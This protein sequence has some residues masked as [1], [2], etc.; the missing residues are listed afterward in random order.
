MDTIKRLINI[1]IPITTCTLRCNYCYITHH[2]LFGGA[3]PNFKYSP[4]EVRRALSKERLGGTC[5]I[6]FCAGGE[7]L[8]P[9]NIVS[10]FKALLDEGHYLFIVTNGTVTKRFDEIAA[11]PPEL[12][13]RTFF[14]FSY[15]YREF[16]E[17]G[18]LDKFFS[19]VNKI[20]SAGASFTLELTPSDEDIPF[21]DEIKETAIKNVGA[22][23]HVTV[24]RNEKVVGELPILTNMSKSDYEKTWSVFNSSFFDYKMSIFGKKR[25][26]FCYAGAWSVY[27]NFVTGD[28]TQCYCS[29]YQQN[30]FENIE[31]PI[32][33]MP[34]GNNCTMQHCY[35]GHSMIVLGTIPEL[36]APTLAEIRNRVCSDGSEWLYPEMKSF[37]GT[38]LYETNQEYSDF[39]KFKVNLEMK[40]R[41]RIR[42]L[43][44]FAG[45]IKRKLIK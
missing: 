37:M 21:I 7:T 32:R 20:H 15:H 8:L 18:L 1:H 24:A 5:L 12:L 35:N 11:L 38:R 13:K 27:L 33:F 39:Q 25:K 4:D 29:H 28:M 22:V 43:R 10:Y 2:R 16:K 23:C 42:S 26:E 44:L 40:F 14:K 45:K 19:N 6:A 9:D 17:K 30:I 41:G 34:I 31:R 36:E 3:L